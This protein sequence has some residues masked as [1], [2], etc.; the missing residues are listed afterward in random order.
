MVEFSIAPDKRGYPQIIFL[1]SPRNHLL[2]NLSLNNVFPL[3]G[4]IEDESARTP[5]PSS[6]RE[7]MFNY[8]HISHIN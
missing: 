3:S 1:I 5:P 8:C 4:R 6:S 2:V 7:G